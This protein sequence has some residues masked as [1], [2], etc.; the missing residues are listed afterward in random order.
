MSTAHPSGWP[1]R[2]GPRRLTPPGSP[3]CRTRLCSTISCRSPF[4]RFDRRPGGHDQVQ[5]TPRAAGSRSESPPC[6]RGSGS[7]PV[8]LDDVWEAKT[9][10]SPRIGALRA[11]PGPAARL[12]N[13][14]ERHF[15][16][17][18]AG[19]RATPHAADVEANRE[20]CRGDGEGAKPA[21]G[22]LSMAPVLARF[23]RFIW[24]SSQITP[25]CHASRRSVPGSIDPPRTRASQRRGV[26]GVAVPEGCERGRPGL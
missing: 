20:T 1:A 5:R 2:T 17:I 19:S 26:P 24:L 12:R 18:G 22:R 8:C 25:H 10:R 21:G 6:T 11:V 4:L 7:K 15:T 14:A 13:L 9:G 23:E 16:P 3:P